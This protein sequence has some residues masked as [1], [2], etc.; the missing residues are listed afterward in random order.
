MMLRFLPLGQSYQ[1]SVI[2]REL[3]K[4]MK[5]IEWSW[6]GHG[7]GDGDGD[8]GGGSVEFDEME[9]MER[10]RRRRRREIMVVGLVVGDING[11]L[12][13]VTERLQGRR[14]RPAEEEGEEIKKGA[15]KVT[16]A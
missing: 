3:E 1:R 5:R 11:G 13:E 8:G 12:R 10:R 15:D 14:R 16:G 7:D 6:S 9:E 4:F 2:W